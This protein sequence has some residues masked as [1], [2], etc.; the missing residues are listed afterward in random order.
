MLKSFAELGLWD[1]R[2][3]AA[4]RSA[5]RH[6]LELNESVRNFLEQDHERLGGLEF[7]GDFCAAFLGPVSHDLIH[8]NHA[9]HFNSVSVTEHPFFGL[10]LYWIWPPVATTKTVHYVG[11]LRLHGVANG[12]ELHSQIV[13]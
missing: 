11:D 10:G 12:L 5:G 13:A 3:R 8:L 6:V 4:G 9:R 1:N 7:D 2:K